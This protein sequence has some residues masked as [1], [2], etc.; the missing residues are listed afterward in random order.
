[1]KKK[2]KE[3]FFLVS[4]SDLMT[5]LFFIMLVIFVFTV[6]IM[7]GK[8]A[9]Q[10]SEI[11]GTREEIKVTREQLRKVEEIEQAIKNIDSTYFEY[12]DEFKKHILKI[13]VKFPIGVSSIKSIDPVTVNDLIK[14]GISIKK[15]LE[16]L[17]SD[18]PKI[19]YLLIIEGQASK[20]N[21]PRNY[22]LS[23]ERALALWLLWR[24]NNID[25]G[26]NCEVII[27]GS[28]VE[29]IMREKIEYL[30]QRFLIHIIPKPGVI[31][32]QN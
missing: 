11:K 21:Y 14:A 18:N 2:V 31:E 26:N 30:N 10:E 8:I 20:D 27:S 23:Y 4:Y 29:G 22:E 32:K 13:R 1:M 7:G 24:N 6:R 25:F 16:K 19:Q 9:H 12:N 15:K 17:R 5:S 28:G 3:S